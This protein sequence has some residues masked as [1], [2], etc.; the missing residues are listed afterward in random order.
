[1]QLAIAIKQ[2]FPIASLDDFTVQ[3]DGDGPYIKAWN[4][5]DPQPTPQQLEAAWQAWLAGEPA[6]EAKEE[7]VKQAHPIARQWFASHQAAIN[8]IRLSPAEQEA[9]IDGYTNA[10]MKTLLKYLTIAVSAIIKRELL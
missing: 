10:Q 9:A 2:L 4:L 6:R 5:P 7:E 8:F 3:D 1:M